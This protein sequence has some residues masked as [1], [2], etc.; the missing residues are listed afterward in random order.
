MDDV[1]C[2]HQILIDMKKKYQKDVEAFTK[3]PY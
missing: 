3:K 2:Y 1:K